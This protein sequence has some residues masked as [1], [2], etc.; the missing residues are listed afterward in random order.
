MGLAPPTQRA[1]T[2]DRKHLAATVDAQLRDEGGE[3]RPGSAGIPMRDDLIEVL[4]DGIERRL[5]GCCRWL[6]GEGLHGRLISML[7]AGQ[8]RCLNVARRTRLQRRMSAA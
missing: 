3:Q 6:G 8:H 4:C 2:V 7:T 5:V 1:D